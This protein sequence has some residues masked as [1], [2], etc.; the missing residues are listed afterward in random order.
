[1]K[2]SRNFE[3][4]LKLVVREIRADLA[5]IESTRSLEL[6]IVVSGR[7]HDGD[8]EIEFKLGNP[9]STG[10]VVKGG[11]LDSV[12]QEYKRRFGWDERHTPLCLPAVEEA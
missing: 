9:Y 4:Q 10:G 11:S 2:D 1:M 8:I 5:Q 3:N 12:V 6:E 7:V